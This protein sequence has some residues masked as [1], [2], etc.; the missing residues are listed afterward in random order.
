[1]AANDTKEQV[2]ENS[3]QSHRPAVLALGFA[4]LAAVAGAQV[5]M[6]T[7][8][9]PVLGFTDISGTGTALTGV[10]DDSE[11]NFTLGVTI[12]NTLF[13]SSDFRVGNNGAVLNGVTSGEIGFTNFPIPATGDPSNLAPG[14]AAYIMPYWDDLFPAG[15]ANTTLYVQVIGGVFIIQWNSEAHFDLDS[16]ERITVQV[17]LFDSAMFGCGPAMQFLYA[18]TFFGASETG[19][20]FGA[21]ATIGYAGPA[22]NA[23]FSFNQPTVGPGMVVSF[24]RTLSVFAMGAPLGP[25]T[26]QVS[27]SPSGNCTSDSRLLA[28]TTQGGAFPN[29]YLFGIDIP[30]SELIY[31][32]NFGPPFT[33]SGAAFSL[34][35]FFGLPSGLTFYGVVLAIENGILIGA[36]PPLSFTIP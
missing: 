9:P 17:Q 10:S 7:S 21:G 4:L 34:G 14:A 31:E 32:L 5:T 27:Y 16:S 29:G 25:G 1:M 3:M 18:D 28:I 11:H 6:T 13:S 23:A 24:N 33:G 19:Y 35:P 26:F 22:G 15:G 2:E 12:A 30:Y 8:I 36:S 20:N